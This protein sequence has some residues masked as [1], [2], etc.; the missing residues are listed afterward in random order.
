MKEKWLDNK[1]LPRLVIPIAAL[2]TVALTLSGIYLGKELMADDRKQVVWAALDWVAIYGDEERFDAYLEQ[3]RNLDNNAWNAVVVNLDENDSKVLASSSQSPLQIEN[4]LDQEKLFG[5]I[6]QLAALNHSGLVEYEGEIFGYRN[7]DGATVIIGQ[8]LDNGV[9]FFFMISALVFGL[10]L[11][12][13]WGGAGRFLNQRILNSLQDSHEQTRSIVETAVD[14]IITINQHSE[15]LTF[16][17]AAEDILGYSAAEIIGKNIVTI[18]GEDH[19]SR[20]DSYVTNYLKTGVASIIGIG[21]ELIA[22]HKDGRNIPIELALSEM[23]IEGSPAFTG[24]IR[25]ITRR[26]QA[27]EESARLNRILREL[28]TI[29]SSQGISWQ[30]K[31]CALLALGCRHFKLDAAI[32]YRGDDTHYEVLETVGPITKNN[33]D[34]LAFLSEFSREIL[35]SSE[36]AI[37][38]STDDTQQLHVLEAEKGPFKVRTKLGIT[39]DLDGD[40]SFL[41]FLGDNPPSEIPFTPTDL[42]VTKLLF[43]WVAAEFSLSRERT[44]VQ[45][46]DKLSSI[47]VLAAGVAHEVNNPLAG[48]IAGIEAL[49]GGLVP[50]ESREIY[51]QTI[52]EGLERIR[53]TVRG[54]LDYSRRRPI[55]PGFVDVAELVNASIQLV[56]PA[57]VKKQL[58]FENSVAPGEGKFWAD[59]TQIMQALVNV[60]LNAI[61]AAPDSSSIY[62]SLVQMIDKVG[63]RVRDEG[64]GIPPESQERV[65]TPFYSTKAEGEGT[66][67][68]LPITQALLVANHGEL[69]IGLGESSGAILTMWL[70]TDEPNDS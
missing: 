13:I 69:D 17:K 68:G 1:N 58:E 56:N 24:I 28:H 39:L 43:R 59:R 6:R 66:G 23:S 46:A 36:K 51:Y 35:E 2:V 57:A 7:L 12:L 31:V 41:V 8:N 49:H 42:E 27:E 50:Q 53:H 63:I 30:E 16:N 18:M 70:P 34:Y 52:R 25:D 54:L 11:V 22:R 10:I 26:K 19:A 45:R 55:T 65:L 64:P 62:V 61:A 40:S 3:I 67:L 15:I 29:G 44:K 37:H 32:F 60:I 14:G 4:N 20:H 33:S 48:V 21:R 9:L 38:E 47:G 5:R